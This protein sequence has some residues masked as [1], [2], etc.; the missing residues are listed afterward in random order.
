MNWGVVRKVVQLASLAA[1]VTLTL[2]GVQ[3][4]AEWEAGTLFS[5]LDPLV[6]LTALIASRSFLTFWLA[7][8]V[9]L[10]ATVVLGRVWCGWICPAGTLVDLVPGRKRKGEKRLAQ[11]WQLGKYAVLVVILG[12]AAL[13]SLGPMILD[14][15]T[16]LTRPIQE[17]VRPLLGADAVARL[18]GATDKGIA[19]IPPAALLSLIPLAVMLGLNLVDK[20]FW[21]R[22]ACPLG[23]LLAIVSLSPGI[24][25][26][27]DAE[28]CTSCGRCAAVCPKDAI[29]PDKGY[30]SS[31]TEC[32]TC[33]SCV[34]A[35]P[36]SACGFPRK[37]SPDFS[38]PYVPERREA[39][40]AM[41]LTG[42]GLAGIMVPRIGPQPSIERPPSTDDERLAQLCVRCGACYSTCPTGIL[43]PSMSFTSIGGPWTP[44]ID[45]KRPSYCNVTCNRC[46]TQCPTGALRQLND[47]EKAYYGVGAT[48]RAHLG[49]CIAFR[50][51][52]QCMK[53]Q[54][55]CPVPGAIVAL[56]RPDF[57]AEKDGQQHAGRNK[58]KRVLVPQVDAEKCIGC[59][60]C[61][62]ACP[63]KPAAIYVDRG[64]RRRD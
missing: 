41:G 58:N 59:N 44:A 43:V 19:A 51:G 3:Q 5:R 53:C 25:R 28:K 23:G 33:M 15:I 50:H 49:M 52:K 61:E 10:A 11:G 64:Q 18:G 30:T 34:D 39:L 60:L 1:F 46:A 55:K 24:R 42:I 17:I 57:L 27:L 32:V 7:A 2:V 56:P 29:S 21:C 45:G 12:A 31:V 35:C 62:Q 48:A 38:P 20:R 26:Q 14:P 4:G 16:I 63:V 22:G 47:D 54:Q 40:A 9:T 37:L 13:G 6:G 36:N 8:G